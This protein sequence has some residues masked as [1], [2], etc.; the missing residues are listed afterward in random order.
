MLLPQ[1]TSEKSLKLH[2][3]LPLLLG[4]EEWLPW[5]RPCTEVSPI[6]PLRPVLTRDDVV[7]QLHQRRRESLAV[8]NHLLLVGLELGRHGL[9]QRHGDPWGGR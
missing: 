4:A 9:L 7:A 8:C 3:N 2:Q 5:E 1:E 6:P